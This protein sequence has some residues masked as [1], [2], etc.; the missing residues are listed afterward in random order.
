MTLIDEVNENPFFPLL[1][2]SVEKNFTK[3]AKTLFT[4]YTTDVVSGLDKQLTVDQLNRIKALAENPFN[5]VKPEMNLLFHRV[6]ALTNKTLAI[7]DNVPVEQAD[8]EEQNTPEMHMTETEI[9]D[10]LAELDDTYIQ[11][12]IMINA[13]QEENDYYD[14]VLLPQAEVDMQLSELF[15]QHLNADGGVDES[16]VAAAFDSAMTILAE[17]STK[18]RVD[19]MRRSLH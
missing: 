12:Q 1:P 13:L 6:G 2:K 19:R 5:M 7:P 9:R 17:D 8:S 3:Q 11:Q 14:N 15:E 18:E 4:Q 10:Q 16:V